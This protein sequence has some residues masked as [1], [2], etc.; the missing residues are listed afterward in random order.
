MKETRRTATAWIATAV[1]SAA[2]FASEA[3]AQT[4]PP[5]G[6]GRQFNSI[7]AF[8][9]FH[10]V[11][12]DTRDGAAFSVALLRKNGTWLPLSLKE[13]PPDVSCSDGQSLSCWEDETQ[14]VSICVCAGAGK[15]TGIRSFYV[16][17]T[18]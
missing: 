6:D 9:P 4:P 15:R 17:E 8:I 1:L 5:T 10:G 7:P 11:D 12:I 18:G 16:D 13:S 14:M 2:V 3:D